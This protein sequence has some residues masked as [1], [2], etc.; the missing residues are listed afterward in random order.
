MQNQV[1]RTR[2]NRINILIGIIFL[3]VILVGLCAFIYLR[4][5]WSTPLG[6]SLQLP[7]WTA[8]VEVASAT[9]T[10]TAVAQQVQGDPQPTESVIR[11]TETALISH[12]DA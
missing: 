3:L 6:P 8:V 12:S 4:P 11:P 1:T 2:K 5:R 7:T 10:A 9:S